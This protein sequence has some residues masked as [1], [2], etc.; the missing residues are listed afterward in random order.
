MVNIFL[1]PTLGNYFD[2]LPILK[3]QRIQQRHPSA[4]PPNAP[5]TKKCEDSF[6]SSHFVHSQGFEPWTH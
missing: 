2:H 5:K 6:E 3:T 1:I 4:A